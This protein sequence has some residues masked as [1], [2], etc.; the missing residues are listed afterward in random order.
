MLQK[1]LYSATNLRKRVRQS[2]YS[3]KWH[4][5]LVRAWTLAQRRRLALKRFCTL[6]PAI[7][8]FHSTPRS[9][10]L[11]RRCLQLAKRGVFKQLTSLCFVAISYR[12]AGGHGQQHT[13]DNIFLKTKTTLPTSTRGMVFLVAMRMR[14]H[15]GYSGRGYFHFVKGTHNRRGLRHLWNGRLCGLLRATGGHGVP[16][17]SYNTDPFRVQCLQNKMHPPSVIV[18]GTDIAASHCEMV[19]ALASQR[20]LEGAV[21]GPT[22]EWAAAWGV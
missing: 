9:D 8:R 10:G 16:G 22:L 1:E 18:R 2:M 11:V 13:R 14:A 7:F 15:S 17:K 4:Q 5:A 6:Y 19:E 3:C 21:V 20:H 12:G